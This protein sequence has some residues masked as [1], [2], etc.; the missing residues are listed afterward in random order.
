MKNMTVREIHHGS[1]ETVLF[2]LP[3]CKTK[4]KIKTNKT[5]KK[6]NKKNRME[7]P[8]IIISVR[9]SQTDSGNLCAWCEKEKETEFGIHHPLGI[10]T[11]LNTWPRNRSSSSSSGSSNSVS[12]S[13]MSDSLQPHGL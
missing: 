8:T 4:T 10:Q 2:V 7:K 13:V 9:F 12:C 5:K 1:C 11:S 3:C 6:K